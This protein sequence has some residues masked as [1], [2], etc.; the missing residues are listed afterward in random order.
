MMETY[1]G[2]GEA[3]AGLPA[4]DAAKT[5]LVLDDAV[6]NSH[7]AAQGGKEEHQLKNRR[8]LVYYGIPRDGLNAFNMGKGTFRDF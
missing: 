5:G 2:D 1:A 7:L 3:S 4:G 8:K 6:W